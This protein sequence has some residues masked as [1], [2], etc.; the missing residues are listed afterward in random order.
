MHSEFICF[1]VNCALQTTARLSCAYSAVIYDD[2]SYSDVTGDGGQGTALVI[3]SHNVCLWVQ[4]LI[5]ALR[6]QRAPDSHGFYI[7][8]TFLYTDV[9]SQK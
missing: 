4:S 1:M 2:L 7:F 9:Y 6:K 3:F 5:H 8:Q